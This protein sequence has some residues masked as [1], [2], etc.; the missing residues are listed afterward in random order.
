MKIKKEIV[1]TLP[2]ITEEDEKRIRELRD[3][4]YEKYDVVSVY[5]NGLYES[6]VVAEDNEVWV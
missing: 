1:Y 4:L 2:N 5:P 3:K 6:R